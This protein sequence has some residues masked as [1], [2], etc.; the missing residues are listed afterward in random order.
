MMVTANPD[1]THWAEKYRPQRLEELVLPSTVIQRLTKI[2]DNRMTTPLVFYGPPGTGKTSAAK[3]MNPDNLLFLN[4]SIKNSV[5]EI[6]H[7]IKTCTALS[8]MDG[9]RVI[10]MDEADQLTKKAQDALRGAIEMLSRSNLFVFTVNEITKLSPA[11]H[12]RLEKV[13]FSHDYGNTEVARQMYERAQAI[14]ALEG[15]RVESAILTHIIKGSFPDMRRVL[16]RLQT[17]TL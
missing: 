3:A 1:C 12:S 16:N 8:F 14:L 2:R 17:E 4:C 6:E 10:V 15:R 13:D 7:L 9:P 5:T 11:L